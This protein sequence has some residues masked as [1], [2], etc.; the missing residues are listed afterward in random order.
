MGHSALTGVA[1]VM[2]LSTAVLAVCMMWRLAKS[3]R[4]LV[5]GA[6]QWSVVNQV[7]TDP[8]IPISMCVQVWR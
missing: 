5:S 2:T 6:G 3:R 8:L 1:V 7:G 4:R